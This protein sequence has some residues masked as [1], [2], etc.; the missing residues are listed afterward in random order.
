MFS[1]AG[2]VFYPIPTVGGR[3]QNTVYAFLFC[4]GVGGI[5]SVQGLSWIMFP[6]G[7]VGESLVMCGSHLLGL[8]IYVSSFETGLWGEMACCFSQDRHSLGLGSAWRGISRLSTGWGP[9]CHRVQF[10]LMLYL[11]LFEDKK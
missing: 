10:Y 5:Q 4:L 7:W 1:E 3:L 6:G 2:S 9:G 8:Q 11:V